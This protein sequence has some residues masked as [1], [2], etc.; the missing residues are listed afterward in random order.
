MSRPT[1]ALSLLLGSHLFAACA[2]KEPGAVALED[3]ALSAI[4]ELTQA[5]P[6]SDAPRAI[7]ELSA[8]PDDAPA[9]ERAE[10]QSAEE[11]DVDRDEVAVATRIPYPA[12]GPAPI[13]PPA[14]RPRAE[15]AAGAAASVAK[16]PT[17]EAKKA[18]AR[19]VAPSTSIAQGAAQVANGGAIGGLAVAPP[20]PPPEPMVALPPVA[21]KVASTEQFTDHGVNPFTLTSN[22]PL[23]TFSIDVD[24]ASYT[25]SRRMLQEGRLPPESAVRVEEFVNY[26]D[27]DSYTPPTKDAF[28]VHLEAMPD[29]FR[30]GRHVVRVGVQGKEVRRDERPPIHLTFLVDVS[31]SMSSADKLE[32]AKRSMRLLVD[33][34]REDDTI[35]LATYAGRTARVLEPTSAGDKARIH[36]AIDGLSSSGSTA[37]SAGIDIAYDMASNAFH[38]GHENR[39]IVLSDG[40]ANV[41]NTSWE[42]ML[43]Q[44]KRH[45]DRGV[46][47]TTIGLGMGNYRDTLMEQLSNKGDGNHFYVDGEA[48]AHRVFVEEMSGAMIT[49]ARDVKIQ[50][51]FDPR[52][53]SAY[54]L[55]GYENREVADADFRNDRVDAGEVGAGHDVTALYEVILKEE[56][57][58]P[59]AQVRLRWERPGADKGLTGEGATEKTWM[60]SSRDLRPDWQVASNDLRIAYAAG[61]F[62]EVLRGSPHAAEIDLGAL[63]RFAAASARKG[64]ADDKELV[65]L[66]ER[67]QALGAGRGTVA[68]R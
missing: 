48:Q 50:V 55:I 30:H 53:V 23:S 59:L 24:T 54:R 43:G 6:P 5:A 20:P 18:E 19:A 17:R 28:A 27:F 39:V 14:E 29:P 56:A 52:A 66:M 42:D 45:A 67:A 38:E 35:A 46:T 63:T 26:F 1:R 62:A 3:D 60:L 58:G 36:R 68:R 57:E 4:P 31:G 12:A 21:D 16:A 61:T 40:D 9:G 32:L 64:E 10:A 34:L 13:A 41:G 22:D 15:A 37:M 49:I 65:Q 8:R 33:T 11:A 7:A 2:A 44:I 47:L 51:E 25:V